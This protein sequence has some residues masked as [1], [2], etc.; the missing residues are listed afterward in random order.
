LCSAFCTIKTSILIGIFALLAAFS[1]HS[2]IKESPGT[3]ASI[4]VTGQSAGPTPFI[5]LINLTVSPAN[6]LKSIQ[7]VIT[8][9]SGSVTRAVSAVYYSDY[10][11]SRG[12][13]NSATGQITLPV[14]GL[15]QNFANTVTVSSCFTD[16]FSQQNIVAVNTAQFADPCGYANPT[17]VQA[18]TGNTDLSYDY[19]L[20]KD[21]C[22]SAPTV[23]DTD[24][25]IRWAGTT[26][27]GSLPATFYHDGFYVTNG[28]QLI[29]ME[30]DGTF[31]VIGDYTSQGVAD[32]HHNIDYGKQGLL[33]EVDTASQVESLVI[34]VDGSGNLLKTWNL[35]TI[36]SAAMTAGG[37]DPTQ[38]VLAYPTDWFHNNAVTYRRSD[39]SLIVSS[40]EDFVICLD[41]ATGAIKWILG[42]PTKKWYQFPSLRQYALALGPSTL[43]PIGQ[44]AVSVTQDDSLLLFDDGTASSHQIPAGAA[45]N[46]SAPRK[47]QLNLQTKVATET[48][49]Y[50]AGQ[51]LYSAFCSSVYE[52]SPLNYLIDYAIISNLPGGN[53]AELVG[54]NAAGTKIFDYRYPTTGCTTAWNAIPLHF[55]GLLFMGAEPR[56]PTAGWRITSVTR[57]ANGSDV[58][59]NFPAVAGKRYRLEFKNALTDATWL[60]LG[61]Y[62][63]PS[64]CAAA[65]MHDASA[66]A[67][68]KR[69]YRVRQVP[70]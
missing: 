54:L 13:L 53:F 20:V 6:A 5:S 9:K 27:F 30:L 12:Y 39:D 70:P 46:Y 24:G 34:E 22:T 21:S 28:A 48:W 29:R 41:Y 1:R 68:V 2:G 42:D 64:T 19:I 45:R 44:H 38:F 25:A 16:G 10:L 35:A 4:I 69:F 14:F 67:Q 56:N 37:D 62:T 49:N 65:Q 55:D 47:Y 31:A 61:E 51:S 33:L 32:F 11:L 36:I 8:P 7:F 57:N 17:V 63:A 15:Y 23:L 18:R 43:P 59:V 58:V 40:R 52:D 66:A 3:A 50:E 26:G 60:P